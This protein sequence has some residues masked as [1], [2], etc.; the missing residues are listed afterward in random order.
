MKDVRSVSKFT[1]FSPGCTVVSASLDFFLSTF[2]EQNLLLKTITE[3]DTCTPVLAA[4]LFT[5][6]RTWEQPRCASADKWIK[7]LAETL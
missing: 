7:Q 6:A 2:C 3:K 4:A 1:F 5:M